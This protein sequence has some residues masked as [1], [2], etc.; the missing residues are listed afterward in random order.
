ML[1]RDAERY[2]WRRLTLVSFVGWAMF[3]AGPR[4]VSLVGVLKGNRGDQWSLI[5]INPRTDASLPMS[6][7]ALPRTE[8]QDIVCRPLGLVGNVMLATGI[9]AL[10]PYP[11]PPGP[12][13]QGRGSRTR[14]RKSRI[15]RCA[16]A[17]RDGRA[18]IGRNRSFG[19]ADTEVGCGTG[20]ADRKSHR[21]R[22]FFLRTHLIALLRQTAAPLTHVDGRRGEL[23]KRVKWLSFRNPTAARGRRPAWVESRWPGNSGHPRRLSNPDCRPRIRHILHGTQSRLPR[24]VHGCALQRASLQ[25]ATRLPIS[26]PR[27]VVKRSARLAPPSRRSPALRVGRCGGQGPGVTTGKLA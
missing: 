4:P 15:G 9:A 22:L 12:D 2:L 26:L 13:G 1:D 5:H 20:D 3:A 17:I 19:E 16:A 18:R 7:R 23:A 6:A 10:V 8:I 24:L 27:V 21:N 11:S 25:S 14:S